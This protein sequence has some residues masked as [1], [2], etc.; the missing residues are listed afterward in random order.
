MCLQV[1]DATRVELIGSIRW[2]WHSIRAVPY[3]SYYSLLQQH[4]CIYS[5]VV[6][7]VNNSYVTALMQCHFQVMLPV[8][9][10][11]LLKWSTF[12]ILAKIATVTND[13]QSRSFASIDC[14][15]DCN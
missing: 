8:N 9:S 14:L 15:I 3:S 11:D 4:S 5:Y 12:A 10:T 1:N 7:R 6:V 2:M 13:A